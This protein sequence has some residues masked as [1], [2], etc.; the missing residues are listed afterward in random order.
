MSAK[1]EAILLCSKGA[2]LGQQLSKLTGLLGTA[3][4][5]PASSDQLHLSNEVAFN[6]ALVSFS[7]A[8][9]GKKSSRWHRS[10]CKRKRN[11][12]RS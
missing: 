2:L 4:V 5:S 6:E 1:L 3:G 7:S 11:L 12:A 9:F 10:R 8:C